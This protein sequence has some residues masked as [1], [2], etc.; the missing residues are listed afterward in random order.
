MSGEWGME[1]SLG[2][3]GERVGRGQCVQRVGAGYEDPDKG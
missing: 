1:G 2:C 3:R